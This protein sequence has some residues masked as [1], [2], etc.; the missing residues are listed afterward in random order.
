MV[1]RVNDDGPT[2]YI[3]IAFVPKEASLLILLLYL[4]DG[5]TP[6]L[7]S[8]GRKGAQNRLARLELSLRRLPPYK[9]HGPYI[10]RYMLYSS[11]PIPASTSVK[12]LALLLLP[13]REISQPCCHCREKEHTVPP[14]LT[15]SFH[16]ISISWRARRG[17]AAMA[18]PPS[19]YRRPGC[20]SSKRMPLSP[21]DRQT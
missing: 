15:L 19:I 11:W 1:T 20:R 9:A 21:C 3:C 5:A 16:R 8:R 13:L 17:R 14:R 6:G 2:R 18:M 4:A 10:R 12:N 7:L